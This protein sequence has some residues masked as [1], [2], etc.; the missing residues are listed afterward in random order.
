MAN[1]I[2]NIITIEG[3]SEDLAAM[4]KDRSV[5]DL[6]NFNYLLPMPIEL[7]IDDSSSGWCSALRLCGKDCKGG[8]AGRGKELGVKYIRNI[9]L[10]GAATW[11][12]WRV[13]HW[14]V[15][16]HA[17]GIKK[18]VTERKCVVAFE[19]AW[20]Y[21][22]GIAIRVHELFAKEY[23]G[24][25]LSW[26]WADEFDPENYLAVDFAKLHARE[27]IVIGGQSAEL[28][29]LPGFADAVKK[30]SE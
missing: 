14:G 30:L 22:D 13:D 17:S 15:K 16:W 11:Y 28:A 7:L 9:A 18:L 19:T 27:R 3:S 24:L 1:I 8:I 25:T 23:P 21:P 5:K 6:F 29:A 2:E 26:K 20:G 4:L 12:D 10:Y